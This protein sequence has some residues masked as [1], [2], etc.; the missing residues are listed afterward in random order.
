MSVHSLFFRY[1]YQGLTTLENGTSYTSNLLGK[2]F[3]RVS[4][5]ITL[6]LTRSWHFWCVVCRNQ[7]DINCNSKTVVALVL[8]QFK[9]YSV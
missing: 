4:S 1:N 6:F 7:N 8:M 9:L 3:D 2:F 5:S